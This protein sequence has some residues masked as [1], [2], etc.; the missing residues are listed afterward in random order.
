MFSSKKGFT[1]VELLVVIAIVSIIFGFMVVNF[2]KGEKTGNL[3]RSAQKI[4]QGVR[5]GQ[6]MALASTEYQGQIYDYYGV[7]FD[8]Q[9]MPYSCYVF[10]S[11]NKVYNPNEGDKT[12]ETIDLEKGIAIDSISTGNKLNVTF[13]PPYAFVAFNPTVSQAVITIKKEGGTCPDDCM[14]IEINDKGWVG[15]TTEVAPG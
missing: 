12:I 10:A 15:L 4:I 11:L 14:Y 13:L 2:R 3:Q 6:N 1:L 8:K 5:K 9:S 7:Y